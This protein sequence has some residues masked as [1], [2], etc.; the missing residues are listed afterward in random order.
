M[1][2]IAA[3]ALALQAAPATPAPA[4][5]AAPAPV[6]AEVNAASEAWAQCARRAVDASIGSGR[7]EVELSASAFAGCTSEEAALRAAVARH[8][9]AAAVEPFMAAVTEDARVTILHYL[10]RA[11]QR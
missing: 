2:M 1:M 10:R 9:G 5:P 7:T 6:H 4:A 8:L 3:I 11:P